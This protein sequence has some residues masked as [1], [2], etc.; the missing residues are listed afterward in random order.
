MKFFYMKKI[1]LTISVFFLL[2]SCG[3]SFKGFY[4]SHKEDIGVTSFQVPNFMK[5]LVGNISPEMNQAIGNISD[6]KF[7]KF[8]SINSFKRQSLI[9]EMN[10]VTKNGYTDVFRKNEIDNTR[11]ISVR[12]AGAVV[13]DVIFFNSNDNLTTAYYL[14]GHFD[15]VK[16]RSFADE[17]KFNGFTNNL[18]QSYQTN[19]NPSI[20]SK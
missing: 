3:S 14:Q 1:F 5:A 9:M 2:F 16:I 6:F 15:P 12:E 10:D 20:N 7:I 18:L 17:D 8:E 4:N 19:I 13:T 11:I